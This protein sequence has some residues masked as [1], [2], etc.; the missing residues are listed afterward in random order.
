MKLFILIKFLFIII[1][2]S[3]S[4]TNMCDYSSSQVDK[5]EQIV[6][7]LLC[8]LSKKITQKYDLRTIGTNVAMPSGIIGLLGLE[9]KINKHLSKHEIRK[10]LLDSGKEFLDTINADFRI[11]AFLKNYPFTYD[12]IDITLYI[13]D[14]SGFEVLDPQIATAEIAYGKITYRTLDPNDPF[15]F[16]TQCIETIEEAK[17]FVEPSI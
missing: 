2:Q 5:N 9:F 12:N 8:H 3:A 15:R 7:Q 13:S 10:I 4:G 17:K 16:K 6:D 1:S 14:P 11:R